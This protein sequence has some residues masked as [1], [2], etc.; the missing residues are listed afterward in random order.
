MIRLILIWVAE[1]EP[2]LS[3]ESFCSVHAYAGILLIFFSLA[4]LFFWSKPACYSNFIRC[5]LW[6][7]WF[8]VEC[9]LHVIIVHAYAGIF[10]NFLFSCVLFFW[11]KPACY[12]NFIRCYLWC[13]CFVVECVLLVINFFEPVKLCVVGTC[14]ILYKRWIRSRWDS[15]P[16]SPAPEASALSIR[17]RDLFILKIF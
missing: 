10:I 8:V 12:S 11:S 5:Y 13:I 4:F 3:A 16:Q 9:V 17:P 6:C 14:E 2:Y 15:N 7:I 1:S